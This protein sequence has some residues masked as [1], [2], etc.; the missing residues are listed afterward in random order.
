[1]PKRN[2]IWVIA[3][4]AAAAVV[5][6]AYPRRPSAPVRGPRSAPPLADQIC[7]RIRREYF[8]PVEQEVLL[9]GAI[10][11]MVSDLD[12]FSSYFPPGEAGLFER[13]M[14]GFAHGLGLRVDREDPWVVVREV[15]P[16][17][18]GAEVGVVP[19]QRIVLL[20]GSPTSELE[21]SAIRALLAVAPGETLSLT[22]QTPGCPARTV[23][24][25]GAEFRVESVIG[26]YRSVEGGWVWTLG[27]SMAYIRIREFV[28]DTP[29][30]LQ[31]AFRSSDPSE[32]LI[33][34]LR[35]NPGGKGD[36]AIQVADLF[37]REGVIVRTLSRDGSGEVHQASAQGTLPDVPLVV[38]VDEGTAS[39]GEL[40]AGAL[41]AR[42]RAVIVGTRTCGKG[43]IQSM[44]DLG[45]D[46]GTI[47]L[48][49]SEFLLPERGSITREEGNEEW[50]VPP[51]IEV[52]VP[53]SRGED[54]ERLRALL[55][56]ARPVNARSS[57]TT[58][59]ESPEEFSRLL[60]YDV[61]L[62]RA[63]RLLQDPETIRA[64]L[65]ET[66]R[67]SEESGDAL[68]G[69]RLGVKGTP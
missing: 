15:L 8:R 2:V 53:S 3:I 56:S 23:Q 67:P 57:P 59:P 25:T 14:D 9:R 38:L 40:L 6:W 1:M 31:Q 29:V 52:A 12:E 66:Q 60:R 32:G 47:N 51:D 36:V 28:N 68:E 26:L 21:L 10:R 45:D 4:L 69:P 11:G 34:D 24:L 22:L 65:T 55:R 41:Q 39:S 33:L 50:G 16:A 42:H 19:G 17:S 49:T 62:A 64:I 7:Q 44:I 35:G 5:F 43:C 54:L 63:A 27:E 18:P 30:R 58:F 46:L 48:T 13:R 61:P 20:D 37:L